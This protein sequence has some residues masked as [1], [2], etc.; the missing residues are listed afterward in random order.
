[1]PGWIAGLK[2]FEPRQYGGGAF[3][4][5][6]FG[7]LGPLYIGFVLLSSL[8]S[9]WWFVASLRGG[10]VRGLIMAGIPLAFLFLHSLTMMAAARYA[11][12]VYPLMMANCITLAHLAVRGWVNKRRL[13]TL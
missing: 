4:G 13:D 12:P 3:I 10:N 11:F 2:Q 7:I 6:F 1:M 5:Q 9:C 8:L